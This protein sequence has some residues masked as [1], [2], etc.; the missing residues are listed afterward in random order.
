MKL[1]AIEILAFQTIV[2]AMCF[3]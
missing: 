1:L 2:A 3:C